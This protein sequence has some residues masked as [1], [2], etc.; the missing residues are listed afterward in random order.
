MKSKQQIKRSEPREITLPPRD[1]QPSAAEL[2][3]ELDMLG[4]SLKKI[5][6]AFFRPVRICTKTQERS[7][8]RVKG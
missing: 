6:E 2:R 8:R 3:E 5:R 1:Y 7:G 4:A